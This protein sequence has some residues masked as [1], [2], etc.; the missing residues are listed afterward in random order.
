MAVLLG[1]SNLHRHVFNNIMT[2]IKQACI[3]GSLVLQEWPLICFCSFIILIVILGLDLS[4]FLG[5]PLKPLKVSAD[6]KN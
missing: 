4:E 2:E 6:V 3:A 1:F 5:H